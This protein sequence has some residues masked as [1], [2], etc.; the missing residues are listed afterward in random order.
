MIAH[1]ARTAIVVLVLYGP[2]AA[3]E[4]ALWIDTDPACAIGSTHDVDDCWAII[5]ALRADNLQV[6]G[7]STVFG[8]TDLGKATAT[9][10]ALLDMVAI[11]EPGH[12]LP[13]V[14]QGASQPIRHQREIP[15]AVNELAKSLTTQRLTVLALGPLTNTALLLREHPDLIAHIEAIVAVA[16]QQPDQVFRVGNTPIVHLHDFNVRKDPEAFEIVLRSGIPIFL[17]PF[18]VA[19]HVVVTRTDIRTLEQRGGL[20]AWLASRSRPWL[21]F[22]E[23]GLGATGFFPFDAL[24]VAYLVTPKDFSC[25]D[26]PARVIRRH[27]LLF[28]RDTLEVSYSFEGTATVRYCSDIARSIRESPIMVLPPRNTE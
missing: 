15:A 3:S 28:V 12:P 21:E 13:P 19:Q 18:E 25:H 8:N 11:H 26:I 2:V 4:R 23:T 5:A 10:Q 20:D 17:I 1:V 27:G 7:L 14:T 16:G 24:A 9:A 22:W 6:I